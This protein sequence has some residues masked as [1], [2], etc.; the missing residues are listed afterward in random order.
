MDR[1]LEAES[2]SRARG[3]EGLFRSILRTR[4]R[5]AGVCG[6][7]IY[8]RH[9]VPPASAVARHVVFGGGGGDTTRKFDPVF[10][11]EEEK[12]W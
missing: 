8:P 11:A 6:T 9:G 3:L 12:Y 1:D 5:M 4:G 10:G 7:E 2:A